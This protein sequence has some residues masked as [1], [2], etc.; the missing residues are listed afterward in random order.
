MEQRALIFGEPLEKL[1]K[2]LFIPPDALRVL[3]LSF[4]GPLDLLLYLIRKDNFDLRNIPVAEITEQY[5]Q[6]IELMKRLDM[7]LAAEYLLMAATLAEIKA[8]LLFPRAA[9]AAPDMPAEDPRRE[10][11]EQL[12]LYAKTKAGAALLEALPLYSEEYLS[13]CA[14]P[15]P[16]VPPPPDLERLAL[17]MA[18]LLGRR[19]FLREHQVQRETL[20]LQDRMLWLEQQLDERWQNLAGFRLADE[21]RAGLVLSLMALLELDKAQILQWRQEVL[22]ADI[23]V[24]RREGAK[25]EDLAIAALSQEAAD[26]K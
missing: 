1:P 12:L 19:E 22:F 3:L 9:L 25:P 20:T 23:F 24:R 13:H 15:L 11:S 14:V 8:R 26:E 18:A 17:A 7:S 5:L 6:Y 4:E 10:L 2:D 16:P 21:G